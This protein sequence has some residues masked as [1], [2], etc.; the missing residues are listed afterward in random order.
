MQIGNTFS[1]SS[2]SLGLGDSSSFL[3]F[4]FDRMIASSFFYGNIHTLQDLSARQPSGYTCMR[5][6]F[7][8]THYA[9]RLSSITTSIKS[10]SHF[11]W[12]WV[13]LSVGLRVWLGWWVKS[14]SWSIWILV[15]NQSAE[16]LESLQYSV[17]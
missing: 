15:I 11:T 4:T 3:S 2:V 8:A 9:L 16:F 10:A 5:Y 6:I 1:L 14:D 13:S 12:G 17:R 7:L